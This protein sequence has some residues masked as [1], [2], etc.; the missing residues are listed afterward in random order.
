MIKRLF[1]IIIALV[2]AFLGAAFAVRNAHP[3]DFNYYL[4]QINLPLSIIMVVSLAAGVLLGILST[5]SLLIKLKF[6]S[7]SYAK[8]CKRLEQ[9][10]QD[11]IEL[12]KDK[13]RQLKALTENLNQK[14]SLPNPDS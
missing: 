5:L 2:V 8:K 3:V 13:D 7:A 10:C 14:T 11:K 9:D 12:I 6:K 1:L 4:G